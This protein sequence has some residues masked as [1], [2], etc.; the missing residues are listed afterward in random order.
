MKTRTVILGLVVGAA[1][2]GFFSGALASG[3]ATKPRPARRPAAVRVVQ[4]RHVVHRKVVRTLPA[5]HAKIV[6]GP[7]TTWY[8]HGVFYRMGPSGY[9]MTAG[10]P[11]A[12]VKVLPPAFRTVFVSGVPY[13]E[14]YGTYYTH[15]SEKDEYVVVDAPEEPIYADTVYLVD[16]RTLVG[17]FVGGSE[18]NLEFEVDGEVQKLSLEDVVSIRFE[19]PSGEEELEEGVEEE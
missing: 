7:R 15:D 10:L 18:D 3:E 6:V 1:M 17:R 14:Y 5:G 2:A 19:P 11:G 9:V 4:R 13:Y 12:R 16:G 8:A